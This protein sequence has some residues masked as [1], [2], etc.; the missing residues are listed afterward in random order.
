MKKIFIISLLFCFAIPHQLVALSGRDTVSKDTLKIKCVLSSAK[1]FYG[2]ELGE[3]PVRDVVDTLVG[4]ISFNDST[5]NLDLVIVSGKDLGFKDETDILWTEIIDSAR[6][7]GYKICPPQTAADLY[8]ISKNM[9]QG[10]SLIAQKLKSGRPVFIGMED[11]EHEI[12]I[13]KKDIFFLFPY[14]HKIFY[15][16]VFC[17]KSNAKKDAFMLGYAITSS[18]N[19]N[20]KQYIWSYNDLFIFINKP[21]GQA[22]S[23]SKRKRTK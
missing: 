10:R 21:P 6:K 19:K 9:P 18:S 14:Y 7:R 16:Y 11:E 3:K 2:F 23:K 20:D 17:L 12:R 8:V 22:V 15:D 4:E 1:L 13:E 5:S